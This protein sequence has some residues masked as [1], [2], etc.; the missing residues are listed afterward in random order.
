MEDHLRDLTHEKRVASLSEL[1]H[2]RVRGD[3]VLKHVKNETDGDAYEDD[4]PVFVEVII[5][6]ERRYL[7]AELVSLGVPIRVVSRGEMRGLFEEGYHDIFVF[8][9]AEMMFAEE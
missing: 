2:L 9:V 5:A 7:T 3:I 6:Y 4:A 8:C 1:L